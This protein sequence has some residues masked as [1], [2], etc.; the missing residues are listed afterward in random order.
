MVCDFLRI[1]VKMSFENKHERV[2]PSNILFYR[3]RPFLFKNSG[4]QISL[5]LRGPRHI[6][7][8]INKH[9]EKVYYV[10]GIMLSSMAKELNTNTYFQRALN[11]M[12]KTENKQTDPHIN[13]Y[14]LHKC[15]KRTNTFLEKITMI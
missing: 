14:K 11:P 2:T 1:H 10:I 6:I 3:S 15:F 4:L 12:R 5:G 8:S 13:N 7:H 9:L